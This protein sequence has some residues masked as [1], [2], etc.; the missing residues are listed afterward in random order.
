[1]DSWLEYT[2]FMKIGQPKHLELL[3]ASR[4]KE[5]KSGL[6]VTPI[7]AGVRVLP[8]EG[9]GYDLKVSVKGAVHMGLSTVRCI[10]LLPPLPG[11]TKCL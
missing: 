3:E 11:L 1:M 4:K 7:D 9:G 2:N 5:S 8:P 10:D 6:F